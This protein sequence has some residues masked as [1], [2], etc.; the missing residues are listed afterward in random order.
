MSAPASRHVGVR[1]TDPTD[2]ARALTVVREHAADRANTTDMSHPAI[3][4]STLDQ[5]RTAPALPVHDALS[6]LLPLTGLR[7]R[8]GRVRGRLHPAGAG[9]AGR[10]IG[11]GFLVRRHRHAGP[12]SD[13]CRRGRPRAVP[14]RPGAAPRPTVGRGDRR[15]AGRFRRRHDPATGPA[16]LPHRVPAGC[17]RPPAWRG[18]AADDRRLA[19]QRPHPVC[20]RPPVARPRPWARPP[21]P[22]RHHDQQPRERLRGQATRHGHTSPAVRWPARPRRHHTKPSP[23]RGMSRRRLLLST[24]HLPQ[25]WPASIGVTRRRPHQPRRSDGT[26]QLRAACG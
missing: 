11:T 4:A 26:A 13:R 2:V 21:A 3:S 9:A 18:T 16:H 20:H 5:T 8:H 6:G 17:P 25:P 14:L 7:A 12:R 10:R 24:P 23:A 19:Q 1:I 22:H 15:A